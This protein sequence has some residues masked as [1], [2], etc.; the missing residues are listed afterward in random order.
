MLLEEHRL[1]N[2]TGMEIEEHRNHKISF[3]MS[4]NY[5]FISGTKFEIERAL[6]KFSKISKDES[7]AK[8]FAQR[9]RRKI[10]AIDLSSETFKNFGE[11]LLS[12]KLDTTSF[13]R[14]MV[15]WHRKD[16]LV[17]LKFFN[18]DKKVKIKK[19]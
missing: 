11:N 13:S 3:L 5:F 18:F 4:E 1:L 9:N 6:K 17:I 19:H 10:V 14:K 2:L 7:I 15:F 12:L 8:N 16:N